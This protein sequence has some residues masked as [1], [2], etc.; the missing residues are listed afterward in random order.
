MIYILKKDFLTYRYTY[1]DVYSQVI[2]I[3]ISV[4][5]TLFLFDVNFN[6]IRC[7]RGK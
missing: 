4:V 3:C 2:R 1:F 5:L 6:V 7:N